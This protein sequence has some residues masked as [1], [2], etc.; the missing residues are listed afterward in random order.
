MNTQENEQPKPVTPENLAKEWCISTYDQGRY[1]PHA[2]SGFLAGYRANAERNADIAQRLDLAEVALKRHGFEQGIV[3]D[4]LTWVPVSDEA[5]VRVSKIRHGAS[6]LCCELR[7]R[8]KE[9][10]DKS[11]A[12]NATLKTAA[13]DYAK[14]AEASAA[15]VEK[16]TRE[17]DL[18]Q[19]DRDRLS[20]GVLTT[21]RYP[22]GSEAQIRCLEEVGE[23]AKSVPQKEW[24]LV[25]TMEDYDTLRAELSAAREEAESAK[26]QL[27]SARN[28][29][30]DDNE[31]ANAALS[32]ANAAREEAVSW[33]SSEFRNRINAET[34]RDS[35]K[36]ALEKERAEVERLKEH[37]SALAKDGE[38]ER[39]SLRQRLLMAEDAAKKGEEAR[40][41]AGALEEG[42]ADLRRQLAELEHR[43][44]DVQAEWK[45][46]RRQ[47]DEAMAE[48]AKWQAVA[49]NKDAAL[50]SGI[51]ELCLAGRILYAEALR[52]ALSAPP[53]TALLEALEGA[54]QEGYR[55]GCFDGAAHIEERFGKRWTASSTHKRY[56]GAMEAGS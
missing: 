56:S 15:L 19:I 33:H 36:A 24:P 12:E 16:L 4:V 1:S 13:A 17:R 8:E 47:R 43:A 39:D 25:C 18:A 10:A 54:Y 55:D 9:R 31:A 23:D 35:L 7:F 29:R 5:F 45:I 2:Y 34:E 38:R 6:G 22:R 28:A 27:R 52:P 11:E 44:V 41:N 46:D 50:N 21:L 49:G 51:T 53:T 48:L 14:A 30:R 37:N 32:A 3:K 26:T 40:L 20:K 42:I